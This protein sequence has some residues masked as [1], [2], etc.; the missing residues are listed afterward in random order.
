M[1]DKNLS[2][3]DLEFR[4]QWQYANS[5]G[6]AGYSN[7]VIPN[8]L[9]YSRIE[10]FL[11]DEDGRQIVTVLERLF[12]DQV[13]NHA[14]YYRVVDYTCLKKATFIARR[15]YVDALKRLNGEHSCTT[16]MTYLCGASPLLKALLL[17]AQKILGQEFV[18]VDTADEALER[19]NHAGQN[20]NAENG[21]DG[22]DNDRIVIY[23]R[24]LDQVVALIGAAVWNQEDFEKTHFPESHPLRV[25]QDAS[26]ALC[27]EINSLIELQQSAREKFEKLFA[28]NP[29][30]MAVSSIPDNRI[31]EVN[32]SVV[33]HLGYQRSEIIGKSFSEVNLFVDP[34]KAYKTLALLSAG[35]SVR[36]FEVQLRTRNGGVLVGH[37]SAEVI[38]NQGMPYLLS[39]I[40]DITENKRA[41]NELRKT[42]DEL[43]TANTYL[44]AMTEHANEMTKRAEAANRAKSAFLATMS[45]EIRTPMNGI[46]GIAGLLRETNLTDEQRGYLETMEASGET[47]LALINDILD[48]S[49]IEAG[50]L[51]LES[52]DFNIIRLIK[53]VVVN[54][55]SRAGSK[56]L[57]L[58]CEI[59]PSVPQLVTGDP[60]RLRQVLVNLVGN[61]VKFTHSGEVAVRVTLAAEM[62]SSARI[63]F[64]VRDT[65]IGIPPDKLG[66]LF[67]TFTQVDSS[68]TRKFGGTGLGLSISKQLVALMGGEIGVHS[69]PGKGSEFWFDINFKKQSSPER[70]N[71]PRD[72]DSRRMPDA[73]LS[74]SPAVGREKMLVLLAEDNKTNQIVATGIL[75]KLGIVRVKVVENGL[76]AV[77]A[78][79][80]TPYDLIFMDIQMPEMDGLEA[81][82][83][84][85]NLPETAPNR[86]VPIIAMTAFAMS[87]DRDR[88]LAAGMNDHIAKP[89]VSKRMQEVFAA[90]L[91]AG[92]G[93]RAAAKAEQQPG[94][95]KGDEPGSDAAALFDRNRLLERLAGDGDILDAAIRRFSHDLPDYL[96]SFRNSIAAADVARMK[97]IA[98][99]IKGVA[100]TL[101]CERLR[102]IAAALE[103][104]PDHAGSG[105][106]AGNFEFLE[107]TAGETIEAMKASIS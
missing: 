85:R 32:D 74:L 83:R 86:N 34:E 107:K 82:R 27:S 76:D 45:H 94:G 26:L 51:D 56:G 4:P 50:K 96:E 57:D 48:I 44:E 88:C 43:K 2:L 98:H 41:E 70:E 72:A 92:S 103:Q 80:K 66:Q 10:G 106:A 68:T 91:P 33:R 53:D 9:F 90:W 38:C 29:A 52:V 16:R 17:F 93:N 30:L 5:T 22:P 67:Q 46:I 42:F 15:H 73:H 104:D 31:L 71:S 95:K 102:A 8:R 18:F 78:A 7:G 1:I 23:R 99:T 37:F 54:P 20:G 6:S 87:E 12:G 3:T 97:A 62:Q 13:L 40:V 84:I 35:E 28:N 25:L 24:D 64:S 19:I 55:A 60:G 77:R 21:G 58:S 59:A 69:E 100:A 36:N 75:K 14:A 11:T 65:G 105:G 63:H 47:L 81:T 61:A 79:A 101:S 39:V 89:I 49:K